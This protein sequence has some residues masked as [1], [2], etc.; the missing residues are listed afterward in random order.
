VDLNTNVIDMGHITYLLAFR[1]APCVAKVW[2]NDADG[3][4]FKELSKAPPG[5]AS[6]TGGQ[7]NVD[8]AGD[9]TEQIRV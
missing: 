8:L 2:L 1:D 3:T 9:F 6:L 7:R 4:F 5:I